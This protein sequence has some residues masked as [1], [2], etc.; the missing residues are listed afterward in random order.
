MRVLKNTLTLKTLHFHP[1]GACSAGAEEFLEMLLNLAQAEVVSTLIWL[2][3]FL[4]GAHYSKGLHSGC[5][6]N[7]KVALFS[8]LPPLSHWRHR[9]ASFPVDFSKN[10][11]SVLNAD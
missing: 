6:N 1:S 7:L 2:L 3:A 9:N 8:P 11:L 10:Q 5:F 4:G